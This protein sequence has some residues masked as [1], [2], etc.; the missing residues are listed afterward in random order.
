MKYKNCIGPWRILFQWVS[1]LLLLLLPWLE[2]DG[3]MGTYLN[4][5]LVGDR[6]PEEALNELNDEIADM[7]EQ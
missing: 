4:L 6:T 5:A 3:K 1:T 2:I 7:L